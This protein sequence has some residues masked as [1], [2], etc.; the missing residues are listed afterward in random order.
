ML[1]N[2][3]KGFPFHSSL[4]HDAIE[5]LRGNSNELITYSRV[6]VISKSLFSFYRKFSL[7][8]TRKRKIL[9]LP[10]ED[11]N[12]LPQKKCCS[13]KIENSNG[14]LTRIFECRWPPYHVPEQRMRLFRWYLV[15]WRQENTQRGFVSCDRKSRKYESTLKQESSKVI[16]WHF[17]RIFPHTSRWLK[18]F[19]RHAYPT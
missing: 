17:H 19:F 3:W 9:L 10:Q 1:T 7:V 15:S 18:S 14:F 11:A 13:S 2:S 4:D 8:T 5:W 16:S 6:L 12:I